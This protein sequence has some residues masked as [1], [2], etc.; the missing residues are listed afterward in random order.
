M[1]LRIP[2]LTAV[3]SCEQDVMSKHSAITGIADLPVHSLGSRQR[4]RCRARLLRRVRTPPLA[5]GGV[6]NTMSAACNY[7]MMEPTR[8]LVELPT[9]GVSLHAYASK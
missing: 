8:R 7:P 6:S 3:T 9:S 4:H 1:T 2:V 5:L